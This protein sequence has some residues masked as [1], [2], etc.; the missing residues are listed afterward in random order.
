MILRLLPGE[1]EAG[2]E[3]LGSSEEV[4]RRLSAAAPEI[5]WQG[6]RGTL[7]AIEL[8]LAAVGDVPDPAVDLIEVVHVRAGGDAD[9]IAGL[10]GLARALDADLFDCQS[11]A[12]LD[13]DAPSSATWHDFIG[14]RDGR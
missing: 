1:D 2:A 12:L 3:P 4:R 7:G 6:A 11:G 13:L 10:C 9:P 8:E 14:L 5:A